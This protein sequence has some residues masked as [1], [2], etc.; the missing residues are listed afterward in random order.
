MKNIL[1]FLVLILILCPVAVMAQIT[2]TGDSTNTNITL[3]Q[4]GTGALTLMTQGAGAIDVYT[5]SVKRW[6]VEAADGDLVPETD[7]SV[8]IGSAAK[9]IDNV[10]A[11]DVA[12]SGA[13]GITGNLTGGGTITSTS[14]G[15]LGWS[16]VTGA[17]TACTT[18]CTSAAVFGVDLAA[19]ASAPVIVGPSAATADACVCAGA[20]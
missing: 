18:T 15:S 19:G 1:A 8:D 20:S 2:A 9:E 11:E 16:Y 14:T 5:T 3:S 10:Y 4:A 12:V 17:N 13:A 7:G 6:T